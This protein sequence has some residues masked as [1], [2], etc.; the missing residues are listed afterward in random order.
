[1]YRSRTILQNKALKR[2]GVARVQNLRNEAFFEKNISGAETPRWTN[3][4]IA[5]KV[6]VSNKD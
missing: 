6:G 5:H 4:S 1:V 2:C 3:G